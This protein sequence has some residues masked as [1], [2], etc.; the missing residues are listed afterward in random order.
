MP[1]RARP[2]T[3][4]EGISKLPAASTLVVEE[5]GAPRVEA[6]RERPA[7]PFQGAGDDELGD[8]LAERFTDAV[9]RHR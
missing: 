5:H 1:L 3:L 4:F 9:E 6:W 7:S 2:R 8:Q